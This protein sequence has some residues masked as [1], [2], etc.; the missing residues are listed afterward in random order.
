MRAGQRDMIT[1]EG[2][3]TQSKMMYYQSMPCYS[4]LGEH[5]ALTGLRHGGQGDLS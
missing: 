4:E 3:M 1:M 5:I 2:Q